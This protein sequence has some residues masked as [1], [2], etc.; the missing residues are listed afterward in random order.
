MMVMKEAVCS[1]SLNVFSEYCL[2]IT[3][4]TMKV[5]A[6][7]MTLHVMAFTTLLT[8]FSFKACP[9]SFSFFRF[10][11]N[12]GGLN[13]YYTILAYFHILSKTIL[14]KR[15]EFMMDMPIGAENLFIK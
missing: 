3:K 5:V 8:G 14:Y 2:K 10:A 12:L 11:M 1:T 9:P 6:E 4:T 15:H 7:A 13:V